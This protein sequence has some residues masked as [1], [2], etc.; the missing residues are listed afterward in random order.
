MTR[1][2]GRMLKGWTVFKHPYAWGVQFLLP[3]LHLRCSAEGPETLAGELARE[4]GIEGKAINVPKAKAT[5][6]DDLLSGRWK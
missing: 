1:G 3:A 2:V 6:N 5:T 4:Q